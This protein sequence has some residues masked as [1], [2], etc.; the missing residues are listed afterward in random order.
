MDLSFTFSLSTSDVFRDGD[1]GERE[2][3]YICLYV[4]VKVFMCESAYRCNECVCVY[5]YSCV[6][7]YVCVSI[8]HGVC[9]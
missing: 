9:L 6:Q 8:N 3:V 2:F 5:I 7:V 1:E 4:L